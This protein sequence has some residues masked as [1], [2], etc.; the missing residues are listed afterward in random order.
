MLIFRGILIKNNHPEKY[1]IQYYLQES[2]LLANEY[3]Q[4]AD[5]DLELAITSIKDDI[6]Q[7]YENFTPLNTNKND[8]KILN[9][10]VAKKLR[11]KEILDFFFRNIEQ[12]ELLTKSLN[13]LIRASEIE[14][15]WREIEN[16][17][18]KLISVNFLDKTENINFL[19]DFIFFVK[20]FFLDQIKELP[21]LNLMLYFVKQNFPKH[22][23][24]S[25]DCSE[26]LKLQCWNPNN[27]YCN[28][29]FLSNRLLQVFFLPKP[30]KK[31]QD[32]TQQNYNWL[33]N[34]EVES[35]KFQYIQ[36]ENLQLFDDS[37][38]VVIRQFNQNLLTKYQADGI[39]NFMAVIY[40]IQKFHTN[41]ICIF[42][43]NYHF[44]LVLNSTNKTNLTK[45]LEL[46]QNVL[47]EIQKI[48][49]IRTFKE[50][51]VLYQRKNGLIQIAAQF[52]CQEEE[53][54]KKTLQKNKLELRIDPS[55]IA[56]AKNKIKFA[57][58]LKTLPIYLLKENITTY[59]FLLLLCIYIYDCWLAEYH[60]F[61]GKL[62]RKMDDLIF[63]CCI[64]ISKNSKYRAAQRVRS[65]I[66]FLKQKNYIGNYKI[67]YP[68][69]ALEAV[70]YISAPREFHLSLNNNLA[71]AIEENND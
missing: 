2:Y 43:W 42:D 64:K 70:Y 6:N 45:K 47:S 62:S 35:I 25:T 24:S 17:F 57:A 54:I 71:L 20:L 18:S 27:I 29:H 32:E 33:S 67:S 44:E 30:T 26:N 65:A 19:E 1:K 5:D 36:N 55:L 41:G 13:F 14:K 37:I 49:V 40:Q 21:P 52:K 16:L 39:S 22:N 12:Q 3:L 11:A 68:K 51:R 63:G 8:K 31:K 60:K 59:P 66:Q 9:L 28:T 61:Q 15:K 34:N 58:A 50:K 10:K 53:Y 48:Q 4:T 23:W 38:E 56:T 69:D 7:L 46:A